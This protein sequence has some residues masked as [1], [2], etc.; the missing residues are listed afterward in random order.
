MQPRLC[1]SRDSE[2]DKR[3]NNRECQ[4]KIENLVRPILR[5]VFV[6]RFVSFRVLHHLSY[7]L[8][9]RD[10]LRLCIYISQFILHSSFVW[11]CI[12]ATRK[13]RGHRLQASTRI[14]NTLTMM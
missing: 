10:R 3:I 1:F 12:H 6:S 7:I 9:K 8:E 11:M 5:A 4:G 13:R 14:Q 2:L